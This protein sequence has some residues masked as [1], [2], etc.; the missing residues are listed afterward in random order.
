MNSSTTPSPSR[1]V[2]DRDV[3]S[4]WLARVKAFD[5]DARKY[6]SRPC[7]DPDCYS[8]APPRPMRFMLVTDF[9]PL[10]EPAEAS[11]E[12]RAD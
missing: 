4:T 9:C 11:R 8:F 12:P 1:D 7:A 10:H 3:P 5:T 2:H 6:G